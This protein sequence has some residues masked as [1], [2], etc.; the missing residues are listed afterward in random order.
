MEFFTADDGA[1][2]AYRDTGAGRPLLCLS[3]LS[4][5]SDDFQYLARH[6]PGIRMICMDYRGRGASDWTGAETYTLMREGQDSVQLLAHLGLTNVP[7]LGTSRGGLI[8]M[9]LAATAPDL[10]SGVCFNDIGPVIESEGLMRIRDYVGRNPGWRSEEDAINGL[11]RSWHGFSGV[12]DTRWSEEVRTHYRRDGDRFV[13]NYDPAL[14]DAFLA[15]FTVPLPDGW[16]FF[17]MLGGK[18]LAVIRGANSDLLSAETVAEMARRH[19]GLIQAEIPNRGHVP[20]LDE[21]EAVNAIKAFLKE[22]A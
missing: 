12:P 4:R 6:L 21:P 8:G 2:I 20:F 15:D 16:G 3:G 19:P 7:I 10:I 22:L 17:D 13:I 5:N 9:G 11:K 14:R 18:T 1:R